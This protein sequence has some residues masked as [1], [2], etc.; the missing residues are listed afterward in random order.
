LLIE[1][2]G[3]EGLKLNAGL[4]DADFAME[5]PEYHFS[6]SGTKAPVY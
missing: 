1:D 3:Y 2:Y 6:S 5:N 4:T